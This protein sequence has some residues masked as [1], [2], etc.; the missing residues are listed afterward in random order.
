MARISTHPGEILREELMAPYKISANALAI[1]LHVDAPRVY[2]I[3][4]ERRAVTPDTAVRLERLFGISAE[5]W[6]NLQAAH[7]LSKTRAEIGEKIEREI[8]P[9]H[10]LTPA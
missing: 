2:E 4:H 1:A 9:R 5:T 6:L 7:D 8:A 3:I 10:E